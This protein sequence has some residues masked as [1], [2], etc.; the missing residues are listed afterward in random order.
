MPLFI[1]IRATV[2]FPHFPHCAARSGD[3]ILG[4]MH[5]LEREELVRRVRG[6]GHHSHLFQVSKFCFFSFNYLCNV[7]YCF[8]FTLI[9]CY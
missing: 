2:E 4:A 9:N 1:R 8:F 7:F 3:Q 6:V 5:V